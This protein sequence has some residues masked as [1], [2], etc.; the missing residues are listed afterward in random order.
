M[1]TRV[2]LSLGVIGMIA[3][4]LVAISASR[5]PAHQLK[6]E[7]CAAGFLLSGIA[8]IALIFPMI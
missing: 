6:L 3:G 2:L 1:E 5:L 4:T 7:R 8:L